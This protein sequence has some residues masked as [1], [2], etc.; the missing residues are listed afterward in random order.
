MDFR[1]VLAFP[2][3]EQVKF[4]INAVKTCQ[5]RIN[6]LENNNLILI[7]GLSKLETKADD[8]K[9]EQ[10]KAKNV[11][12]FLNVGQKELKT[13]INNLRTDMESGFGD[14]SQ[15][16]ATRQDVEAMGRNIIAGIQK[17]LEPRQG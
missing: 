12:D 17:V 1:E 3:E 14:I 4:L 6:T 15:K 11:L 13:D 16:M 8:I 7:N 5:D 10:Q 2:I 9:S